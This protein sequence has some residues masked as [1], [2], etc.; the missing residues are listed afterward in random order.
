MIN[1]RIYYERM[2]GNLVI[3]LKLVINWDVALNSKST[4]Q[5]PDFLQKTL[6]DIIQKW[7]ANTYLL[8][9]K[10]YSVGLEQSKRFSGKKKTISQII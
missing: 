8:Q 1:V 3:N 9:L 4:D 2:I 6:L 7:K 5:S 10:F